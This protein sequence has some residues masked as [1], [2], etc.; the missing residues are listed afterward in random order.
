VLHLIG[1]KLE[2]AIGNAVAYGSASIMF[3][4]VILVPV[5]FCGV[6]QG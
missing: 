4:N 3:K 2:P 5:L 6:C 1:D